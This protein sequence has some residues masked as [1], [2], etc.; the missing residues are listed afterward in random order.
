MVDRVKALSERSDVDEQFRALMQRYVLD[1]E[2]LQQAT[3][4]D[5][6]E[7]EPDSFAA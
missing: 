4:A 7:G 1:H 3:S 2:L 6:S 5:Y